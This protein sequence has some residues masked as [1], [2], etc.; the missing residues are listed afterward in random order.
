MSLTLFSWWFGGDEGSAF[1][2]DVGRKEEDAC[3]LLTWNGMQGQPRLK[4]LM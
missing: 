3:R 4:I 2:Y 1:I